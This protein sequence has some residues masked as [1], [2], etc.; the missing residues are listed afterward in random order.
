MCNF[1][2]VL[3]HSFAKIKTTKGYEIMSTQI[4]V[5]TR[6]E[7]GPT[8]VPIHLR[9]ARRLGGLAN[10]LGM[11]ADS[12]AQAGVMMPSEAQQAQVYAEHAPDE[13]AR[14]TTAQQDHAAWT[15]QQLAQQQAPSQPNRKTW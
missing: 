12:R 14:L 5:E 3:N 6:G 13:V 8:Q 7:Q 4:K 15:Q 11:D 1:I 10:P 9:V 2:V